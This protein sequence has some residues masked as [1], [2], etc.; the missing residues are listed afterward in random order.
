MQKKLKVIIIGA[1]KMGAFYDY[2]NSEMILSHAHIFSNKEEFELVG[3]VDA[4]G[5][6][7][8]EAARIWNVDCFSSVTE[9]M[10]KIHVDIAVIAAPD[11]VHFEI[12]RQLITLNIKNIVLE[13]PICLTLHEA[14]IM[15]KLEQEYQPNII[16]NYSRRFIP[17][18]I[19]LKHN[20][21]SN[22][23]GKFLSGTGYYGKGLIHNGSHMINLLL[24]FFEKVV[25][26]NVTNEINDFSN[27]DPSIQAEL[28]IQDGIFNLNY[29]DSRIYTIF[30]MDLFFEK[31]RI[32][33]LDSGKKIE[34]YTTYESDIYVGYKF[35]KPSNIIYAQLE[36]SLNFMSENILQIINKK[37]KILSSLEDG[38]NTL[39]VCE[40]IRGV[41]Q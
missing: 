2:P 26:K 22:Y 25:V 4:D 6:K 12:F 18:Y 16:V 28:Q 32:R 41:R 24:M 37:S 10:S 20:I 38:I 33:L 29:I 17:E 35:I 1:G 19:E 14:K 21:I 30:E 31:A 15:M 39:E 23:Y 13:K 34:I 27:N 5:I 3:F 36:H 40:L 9:V 7:A 8:Q 11:N